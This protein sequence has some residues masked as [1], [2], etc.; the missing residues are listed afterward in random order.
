MMKIAVIG[1]G[2]VGSVTGAC[3][4]ELGNDV[5]CIDI[6][7]KKID[8]MRRGIVP[9]FEPGLDELF[10]NN[11][12]NNRLSFSDKLQDVAEA[13]VIFLALPTPSNENG[14]ADLS[15]I[16]DVAEQLGEIL[17]H[18]TVIVDKS[19]VPVGTASRVTNIISKNT[20]KSFD[21]V[22]NPEFLREGQAIN[23]FFNPDRIVIGSNSKKATEIMKD[24]YKPLIIQLNTKI[25]LTD[26]ASA[27]MIK[28][29]A[30]SFLATKISF[31]NQI[32]GFCE[33]V[34]ADIE[35][36]KQGIGAD[37]RIGDKFLNPGPGFGGSCFPK[38]VSAFIHMADSEKHDL[39][40]L[41]SVFSVNTN[42]K[43]IIGKKV[44]NFFKQNIKGRVIAVWGLAFKD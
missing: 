31:I 10:N 24:L 43:G 11:I 41:K 17:K 25:I 2:Y 30:N 14:S 36:V 13:E 37:S 9:I 5:V 8:K 4:A 6:D 3:F 26:P 21:V 15:Y 39:S 32:S 28:Y 16:L 44:V 19:T 38:D 27:E 7:E 23:D 42:Q 40:I 18:Y 34:G 33:L 1:T 35:K 20:K 12:E 29:A 22:S